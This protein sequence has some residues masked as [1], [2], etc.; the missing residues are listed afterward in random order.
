MKYK[1]STPGIEE[2]A[3]MTL[4]TDGNPQ[5]SEVQR[6]EDTAM[7]AQSENKSFVDDKDQEVDLR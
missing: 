4:L 1:K 7:S 6:D 5:S 3:P 2:M